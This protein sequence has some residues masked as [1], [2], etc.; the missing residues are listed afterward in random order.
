MNTHKYNEKTKEYIGTEAAQ[1]DPLETKKQGKNIYLLPA[2]ATFT[3]PQEAAEGFV[4]VWNGTVWKQVED[5]RGTEYWLLGDTYGTPAHVMKELG[6]LPEGAT[7]TPPEPPELTEEEK[8]AL[9]QAQLT[10]AVQSWM[11]KTV[12][13]RNY[14]NIHS[15]CTYVNSTDEIFRAEGTACLAWRDNVWR[16]C[17]NILNDVLSGKREIPTEEELIAE[18][19]VLEW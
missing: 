12:Q 17:Y 15:A 14:D 9:I 6:A 4:N 19:P 8:Q 2:N 1:L 5:H 16:T 7:L 13:A 10:A 3:V 11:D 18:L